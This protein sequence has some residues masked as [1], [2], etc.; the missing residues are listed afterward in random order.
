MATL[1]TQYKNYLSNHPDSKFT[2]DEWK[3]TVFSELILKGLSES[4]DL[5]DWDITINDGL[6]DE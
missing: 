6:E 2:F 1:E 5:T 3:S 4:D